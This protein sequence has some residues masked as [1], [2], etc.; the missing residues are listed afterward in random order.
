MG[1]SLWTIDLVVKKTATI[2]MAEVEPA[3]RLVVAF[4]VIAE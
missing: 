4:Y 3:M 1:Q 2:M